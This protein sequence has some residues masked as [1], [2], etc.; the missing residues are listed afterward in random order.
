M[1]WIEDLL[2]KIDRRTIPITYHPHFIMRESTRNL[3]LMY[4]EMTVR[5][6]KV[7]EQRCEA[8]RKLCFERYFGKER[9]TYVVIVIAHHYFWEVITCWKRRGR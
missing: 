9:I 7:D 3:S 4:V 8:P 6:G 5:S 2:K 1:D